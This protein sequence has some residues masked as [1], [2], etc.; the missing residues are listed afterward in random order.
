MSYF[1]KL[2]LKSLF[3]LLIA[4]SYI[5]IAQAQRKI[6]TKQYILL[7]KD[8]AIKEMKKFKIPASITLAQGILESNSG[9]STLARKANNHFGIKCHKNWTGKT[10]HRDDDR[11]NECFRKYKSA[12]QSFYDHS[13]FLSKGSRYAFLFDLRITNYKAWAKGLKKAG[14][15]TDPKYA[16]LLIKIIE[17]YELYIYDDKKYKHTEKDDKQR[18]KTNLAKNV[19]DYEIN[20]FGNDIQNE[21][22]INFVIAK[23]GDTF[24]SIANKYDMRTWQL[25]KYNEITRG[26]QPVV[27]QRIYLQPKRRKADVKYKYHTVK[28]NETMYSISQQYGIKLKHLYRL[29]RLEIG[30]QPEV[31]YQLSLR[32][33][34]KKQ[35]KE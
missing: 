22:R 28:P 18:T 14:Y 19:D 11:P 2:K 24:G 30:T 32:K 4:T 27:G 17:T 12:E 9:N 16:N 23:P 34:V 20:P 33:R 15:A 31:G 13:D 3:L 21:N 7:Y 6:S 29:N 1:I 25:Y 26:V 10:M 5:Q 35:K 8:V